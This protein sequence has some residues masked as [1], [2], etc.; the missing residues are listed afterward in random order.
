MLDETLRKLEERIRAA[1]ADEREELLGLVAELRSE[2]G[3]VASTRPDDAVTLA[4]HT[5]AAATGEDAERASGVEDALL[6][7]ETAHP[8]AVG[9]VRSFLRT[10]A[11]AG[12]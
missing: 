10:L 11:A 6:E 3:D 8:A 5:H 7:F 4:R 12:I 1:D 9:L 2:L